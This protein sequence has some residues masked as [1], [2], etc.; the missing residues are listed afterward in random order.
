MN[1]LDAKDI[2]MN[3]RFTGCTDKIS[4]ATLRLMEDIVA[5]DIAQDA[6]ESRLSRIKAWVFGQVA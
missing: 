5:Y 4:R 2:V 3:K 1:A 6:R